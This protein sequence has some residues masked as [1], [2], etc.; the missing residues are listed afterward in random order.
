MTFLL[1]IAMTPFTADKVE[2]SKEG[3]ARVVNLIGNVVIE[4]GETVITCD[5]AVINEVHGW[6]RLFGAVRLRDEN[7][8]VRARSAMYYFKDA[9][10]YMSDS[11]TV[12]TDGERMGSD[13][14]YYDGARDSVE[15]YGNVIIEDLKN[16]MI[17]SGERGRYNLAV[18]E[19]SLYGDPELRILRQDKAPIVVHA[20]SFQLLTRANQFHGYDSVLAVIDSINVLC[21]TF[22]YD[23]ESEGGTM[24]HPVIQEKNN[25]LR[26]SH[27]E[28]RMKNKE[29]ESL[30]VINGH[31]IY[32]TKEGSKNVVDGEAISI[33]FREGKAIS[34]QV[35]G[36]PSG[37]LSMK[38]SRESAGD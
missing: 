19:G 36:L 22:S 21:D 6:V 10:G 1:L 16:N 9:R 26:G 7:G 30:K 13:S 35:E 15:M 28:F 37:V 5:E 18:D 17:V 14:L 31:S 29:I 20:R 12:I 27:G 25:E 38:R 33:I 2:I 11:V 24:T 32:Y 23:M 4:G 3:D 34:I 8:E